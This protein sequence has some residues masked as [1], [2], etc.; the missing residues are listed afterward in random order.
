MGKQ[1]TKSPQSQLSKTDIEE[2]NQTFSFLK[3]DAY[4]ELADK[5][6]E[7]QVNFPKLPGGKKLQRNICR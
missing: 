6:P 2:I 7:V 3:S 5:H 4:I 1:K